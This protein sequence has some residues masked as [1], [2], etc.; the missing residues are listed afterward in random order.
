MA[1]VRCVD[2]SVLGVRPVPVVD[3]DGVPYE[4]TLQ[5]LRDGEPYGD[6]GERCGFFLAATAR[7][8][9]A[10]RA[11]DPAGFPSSSVEAGVRSYAVDETAEP[12]AVWAALARYLPRDRELFC[13]RARDPDD[14]GTVG[15][16]RVGLEEERTWVPGP[17]GRWRIDC[18]AVLEAWGAAGTGVRAVLSSAELQVFLETLV[19]ECGD[20]GVRHDL[21]EE[22]GEPRRPVG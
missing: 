12:G 18:R 6:V 15:E 3:R 1:E 9:R 2:G 10:V 4:V 8:L 19:H 13:F 16:I 22:V 7:R 11:H 5:L 17:P 21:D 20:V 14:L